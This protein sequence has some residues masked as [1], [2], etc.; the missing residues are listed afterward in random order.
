LF[1]LSFGSL[2]IAP[3]K[4]CLLPFCR[5]DEPVAGEER[6]DPE[7]AGWSRDKLAKAEQWS[8]RIGSIT[9]MVVAHR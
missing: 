2:E 1:R 6:V 4:A 3:A 8:Q 9:V 5:A 7:A